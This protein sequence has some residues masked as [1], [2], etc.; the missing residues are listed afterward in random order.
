MEKFT[1]RKPVRNWVLSLAVLLTIVVG[2]ALIT[3]VAATPVN[4]VTSQTELNAAIAAAGTGQ[5][6]ITI[7]AVIELTDQIVIP[8]GKDILLTSSLTGGA[9]A[10]KRADGYIGNILAVD[11]GGTLTTEN[12]VISGAGEGNMAGTLVHTKGTY[13]MK[14]GTVLK[15]NK[16]LSSS[17]PHVTNYRSATIGGAV[18]A[19]GTSAAVNITGGTITGNQCNSSSTSSHGGGGITALQGATVAMSG[20]TI[21]LN[22]SKGSGG[23]IFSDSEVAITANALI[24]DNESEKYGGGV[25]VYGSTNHTYAKFTMSGGTITKNYAKS[26]GGAIYLY[27]NNSGSVETPFLLPATITKGIISYNTTPGTGGGIAFG[28]TDLKILPQENGDVVFEYNEA[29][30]S[31]GAIGNSSLNQGSGLVIS[32]GIFRHNTAGG[33]GGAVHAL[34]SATYAPNGVE[35]TGGI[36]TYNKANKGGAFAGN[37]QMGIVIQGNGVNDP[38]FAENEAHLGG[39]L[40]LSGQEDTGESRTLIGN[41][42]IEK[43]RAII[44]ES[45]ASPQGTGIGG[46]IAVGG[47]AVIYLQNGT[48]ITQNTAQTNGGGIGYDPASLALTEFNQ[49]CVSGKVLIGVDREDNGIHLATQ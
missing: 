21:S 17:S 46:G 12:I 36:F 39:A 5:T 33:S 44:N 18:Y 35:I 16:N 6:T 47:D 22:K 11:A 41:A 45:A 4:P 26:H 24:T 1:L 19:H 30:G 2:L 48:I 20:G 3:P 14:D 23:G 40:Y 32:G 7:T 13:N 37:A 15:D 42:K 25:C 8:D 10:L 49:V 9:I 43:N 31:G 27:N 34:N 38:Y 28:I 29:T